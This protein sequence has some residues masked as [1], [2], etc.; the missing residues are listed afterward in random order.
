[1]NSDVSPDEMLAL[2]AAQAVKMLL[3]VKV[4][5]GRLGQYLDAHGVDATYMGRDVY[6]VVQGVHDNVSAAI[7][8]LLPPEEEEDIRAKVFG[9]DDA[10]F[11]RLCTEA[12]RR[13]RCGHA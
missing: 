7:G 11:E 10:E 5:F 1:M 3:S 9:A 4:S 13:R 8:F 12:G 2:A 6:E